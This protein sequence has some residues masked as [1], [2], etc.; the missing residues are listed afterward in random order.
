MTKPGDALA[1][2][3]AAQAIL[4]PLTLRAPDQ[5]QWRKALGTVKEK[6]AA[7]EATGGKATGHGQ[8]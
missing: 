2:F 3:R 8:R 7:I 5:S 1:Q 4:E 6:I